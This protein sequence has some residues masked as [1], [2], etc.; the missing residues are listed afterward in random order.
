[1]DMSGSA[2]IDAPVDV[3][4]RSLND[5]EILR[6][7]IP[8]C[9]VMEKLSETE[10]AATLVLKLGPLKARFTGA[11]HLTNLDPPQAYTIAAEGKGGMFGFARGAADV[12]LAPQPEGKTLLTY[13]LRA[14][15]GGRIAQLGA[16]LVGSTATH[17]AD[18]FFARFGEVIRQ[19]AARSA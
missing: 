15:V 9:E 17:L 16:R 10:W 2:T 19:H 11:V 12:S 3:V 6:K 14:D 13:A 5:P 18:L 7:C 1:M 4:W 8:G